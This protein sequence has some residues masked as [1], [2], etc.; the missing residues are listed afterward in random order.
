M[1]CESC[2]IEPIEITFPS[3]KGLENGIWDDPNNKDVYKLC[4]SCS[5]RLQNFALRPLEY[6]NLASIHGNSFHLHDDFYDYETGEAFQPEIE[7]TEVD[8][9]KFPQFNDVKNDLNRLV[10]FSIVQFYTDDYVLNQLK[11]FDK[12]ELIETLKTKVKYN[13]AINYKAYEIAGKVAKSEAKNWIGEEWKK[14]QNN[15]LQMFAEPICNSFET[16]EAFEVIKQELESKD[17]IYLCENISALLYLQSP[18]VL[19]WI[20]KMQSRISNVNSQWGQLAASSKFDWNRAS[21]WLTEG[22]PLSLIAL[23]ALK[24]C[25]TNGERLNQSL[26]MRK[27]NPKL[28]GNPVPEIISKRLKK[29]QEKDNVPRTRNS[30]N[31]IIENIFETN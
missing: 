14:R 16:E 10:D 27:L 8:R 21:N 15:E 9:L 29:Y 25:T 26:W 3:N 13:R 18:L 24:L 7:V 28:L 1:N 31:R 12:K 6:F 11:Q 23:D 2:K 4:K 20:E 30:I 22:R 5:I 17:D 19:N